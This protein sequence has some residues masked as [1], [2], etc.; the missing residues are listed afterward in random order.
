MNTGVFGENFPY[1][2]FHD[3]NLDW[4]I[5]QMVELSKKV[6]NA[7]KGYITVADPIQ[8]NITSQYPA[9]TI[10]LDNDNAY[11]STQAVPY[12]IDISNSDYW[13][14]IFDLSEIF[15]ALKDSICMNDDGNSTTSSANRDVNTY[16]WRNNELYKVIAPITL[17]DTYSNLNVELIA[18]SDDV[19][20]IILKVKKLLSNI[21]PVGEGC[22]YTTI[23]SAYTDAV[24]NHGGT[25]LIYP[26]VYDE[27]I[28]M[29]AGSDQYPISFIGLSRDACIW[30]SSTI[31]YNNACFTGSGN[32]I[33]ENLTMIKGNTP[34][35][36]SGGGYALHMDYPNTEGDMY[37]RNCTL[38]SYENSALGCG[39]RTNQRIF[40]ENCILISYDNY[41]HTGGILYH[42]AGE[43]NA[44]G[45]GLSMINNIILG[46][47]TH[48][49][50]CQILVGSANT[51]DIE[52]V[53]INNYVFGAIYNDNQGID[54]WNSIVSDNFIGAN[55]SIIL[56]REKCFGNSHNK[57][58]YENDYTWGQ[59]TK[60]PNGG[61]LT[62]TSIA[63]SPIK[64]G[65]IHLTSDM[66][67]DVPREGNFYG[68]ITSYSGRSMALV[69]DYEYG[70]MFYKIV[71]GSTEIVP[72]RAMYVSSYISYYLNS[73]PMFIEKQAGT[74]YIT[75]NDC[76]MSSFNYTI[77]EGWRSAHNIVTT[78]FAWDVGTDQ[79]YPIR[80]VMKSDGTFIFKKSPN[81][82]IPNNDYISFH[83]CYPV[84]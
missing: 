63:N 64:N 73:A 12:G 60:A 7:L 34:A 29:I 45:Q 79:M 15:K 48:S 77:P 84:E 36:Q 71:Q 10:V 81:T 46:L 53:F 8:W 27:A 4:I 72:W 51:E 21:F 37:V 5:K 13:Q 26:G 1:T 50:G 24:A 32:L 58:N 65:F 62:I 82:D 16:V 70:T 44:T 9:Y 67:Q 78:G 22:I 19:Y 30:K 54:Y 14:P 23:Q 57:L 66:T 55:S 56:K 33:F 61:A 3:L 83:F 31:G 47:G 68:I 25:I 38:I 69:T 17:G 52:P 2:N 59:N 40:I 76:Q 74:V 42:A 6:D 35:T 39:T 75:C 20:N 28:T 49:A 43:A 80:V 18:I 41:N 11:L